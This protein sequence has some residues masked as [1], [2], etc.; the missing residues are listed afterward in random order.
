[1]N[2]IAKKKSR[3]EKKTKENLNEI[4]MFYVIAINGNNYVKTYLKVQKYSVKSFKERIY[5][6]FHFKH[7]FI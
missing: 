2:E 7:I 6:T 4:T 5:I 1:M 3:K